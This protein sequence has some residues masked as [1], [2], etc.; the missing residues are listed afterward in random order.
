MKPSRIT[1]SFKILIASQQPV[2]LWGPPG[3]GKS[4]II[5]QNAHE[6]GLQ[7]TDIRA[8]LLDPVDHGAKIIAEMQIVGRLHAGKDAKCRSGHSWIPLKTG[9]LMPAKP[10]QVKGRIRSWPG[11][12]ARQ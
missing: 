4:Q 2:F 9:L 1:E 3:V 5:H 10:G 12:P 11:L 8:I 7:V 6:L